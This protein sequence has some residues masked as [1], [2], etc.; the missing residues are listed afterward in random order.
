MWRILEK[1]IANSATIDLTLDQSIQSE[2][3]QWK[4]ILVRLLDITLFLAKMGLPFR[5]VTEKLGDPHNGLFLGLCEFFARYDKVLELQLAAVREAQASHRQIQVSYL[6]KDTQ[7]AFIECCASAVGRS[8]LKEV[9][10]SKYYAVI[11]VV[12]PDT[13]SL[14]QNVF[15]LRYVYCNIEGQYEVQ[16][17]FLD[18]VDNQ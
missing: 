10:D 2:V 15:V 14:E 6:S 17:R 8:L 1:T 7:N 16:E 11:V 3:L 5:G 12:T 4:L 9:A 18:F 13:S